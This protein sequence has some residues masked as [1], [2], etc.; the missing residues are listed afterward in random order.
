M[1]SCLRISILFAASLLAAC[2]SKKTPDAKE[3]EEKA[4]G[5]DS[6]TA[7]ANTVTLSAAQV[8]NGK[9]RWSLPVTAAMAATVE[10]P[11]QIVANEDRTAR[12]SAPAESRAIAVHVSPGQRVLRGAPLVTLQSRDANMARADVAKAQ[13]EVASRQ[14]SAA[15]S[16]TARERA[17]RLL[18]LKSIPKQDYE[19]AIADDELAKAALSQAR[20][21]L[22]RARSSAQQLGVDIR[23][24][25]MILRSPISGFVVSREVVPGAVVSPGAPLV[26]IT[27]PSSLWLT[28]A[29]PQ[30][31]SSSVRSGST[32]RFTVASL[33]ADT[34]TARVQSVGAAFDPGTRSLPVRAVVINAGE[35]LRPEMFAKAWVS[36]AAAESYPTVP[37]AAIQRLGG[38]A[39]VLVAKPDG[40]GGATFEARE[41]EIRRIGDR[42]AVIRGLKADELVVVEGAFAV[43]SQLEKSKMPDME[44]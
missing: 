5:P 7:A 10:V 37:D 14:A 18:A 40:K 31:L 22:I 34:F 1:T 44:M 25:S 13:A 15:Y 30:S 8:Q 41:V 6:A 32:V 4:T 2:T 43:R 9:V 27:D 3:Q 35:R 17:E 19:R 36:G 16:R 39:V 12:V 33:P 28:I 38:K 24:G 23:S 29:L 21:E 11:A 26:T 20:S 42:W